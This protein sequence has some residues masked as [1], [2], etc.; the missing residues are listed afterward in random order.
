MLVIEDL[1]V[2]GMSSS[3]S[4]T[5]EN[6]GRHVKAKAGLNKAILDQGWS[7]FRRCCAFHDSNNSRYIFQHRCYIAN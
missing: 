6:P 2:K 4:G 7:E 1:N 3:A 5:R